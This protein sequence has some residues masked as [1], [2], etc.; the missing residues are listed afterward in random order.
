MPNQFA[1]AVWPPSQGCRGVRREHDRPWPHRSPSRRGLILI[2]KDSLG[3]DV[4]TIDMEQSRFA[5]K[6][7]TALAGHSRKG[8]ADDDDNRR[9][10]DGSDAIRWFTQ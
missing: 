6:F 5:V 7:P 1:W 2:A 3:R 4:G 9:P 8:L 10:S